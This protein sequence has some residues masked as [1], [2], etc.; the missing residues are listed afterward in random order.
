[1][2]FIHRAAVIFNFHVRSFQ[3]SL[4]AYKLVVRPAFGRLVRNLNHPRP[5][6]SGGNRLPHEATITNDPN[7]WNALDRPPQTPTN[8]RRLRPEFQITHISLPPSL[9]GLAAPVPSYTAARASWNGD[10]SGHEV[11]SFFVAPSSVRTTRVCVP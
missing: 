2:L 8:G 1:V 11:I 9:L 5:T 6:S 3:L 10:P 4:P 7:S